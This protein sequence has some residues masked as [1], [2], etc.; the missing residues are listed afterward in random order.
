MIQDL[1]QRQRVA[2]Y[3]RLPRHSGTVHALGQAVATFL[4]RE[5]LD[6]FLHCDDDMIMGEATLSRAVRDY[7][8]HLSKGF[9]QAGGVLALF[10]NS[11][12]LGI[13]IGYEKGGSTR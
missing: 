11:W 8:K 13:G 10:V 12:L 9:S 3:T 5:D 7:V 1:V 2:N 4:Q 6:L